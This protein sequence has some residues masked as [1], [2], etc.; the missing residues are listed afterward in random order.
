MFDLK[1][2][3][4]VDKLKNVLGKKG[5]SSS[6]EE[7]TENIHTN[8]DQIDAEISQMENEEKSSSKGNK[9]LPF[10][11]DKTKIIRVALVLV[12]AYLIYDQLIAT[13]N[14]SD[15]INIP[16]VQVQKNKNKRRKVETA[17]STESL[18]TGAT[19]T[20][21]MNP[22][23]TPTA[24]PVA[25][26][27]PSEVKE[28]P[29]AS[30]PLPESTVLAEEVAT[31]IPVLT[32]EVTPD[33][34]VTSTPLPEK[35]PEVVSTPV[36]MSPVGE[37]ESQKSDGDLSSKL[38]EMVTAEVTPAPK[39]L[40][41]TEYVSPPDFGTLGRGLVY[42]CKGKHWACVDKDSFLKCR[43]NEVWQKNHGKLP[44][45]A[46]RNVYSSIDDCKIVQ[47]HNINVAVSTDFCN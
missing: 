31:P 47:T 44:E 2:F 8:E 1:K 36:M 16:Q 19:S 35:T 34:A 33:V 20:E 24:T 11:Q 12:I 46:A 25:E 23:E 10:Y 26:N 18:A 43:Q 6:E 41:V 14:S 22:Q 30:T 39:K 17:T 5:A 37:K 38:T 40:E 3:L 28:I 7:R 27:T 15:T 45:C 21:A 42:N 32:P 4:D 9:N 29:I 13:D